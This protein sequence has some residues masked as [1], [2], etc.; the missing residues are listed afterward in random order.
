MN[1]TLHSGESY[2]HCSTKWIASISYPGV[3]YQVATIS[4]RGK[5]ELAQMIQGLLVKLEHLEA[6]R[7]STQQLSAAM[8]RCQLDEIYLRWGFR[9]IRGLNIDGNSANLDSLIENGPAPLCSE[10]CAAVR[11]ECGLTQPERKN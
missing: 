9:K 10:I 11:A 8:V 5:F 6:G 4:L 3:E 2:C 7:D 1:C